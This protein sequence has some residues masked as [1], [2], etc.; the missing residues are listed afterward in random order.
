MIFSSIDLLLAHR[1][2]SDYSWLEIP[3]LTSNLPKL[4]VFLKLQIVN[5]FG[6]GELWGLV[7]LDKR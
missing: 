3:F 6:K 1:F 2:R 4:V 5:P 7:R